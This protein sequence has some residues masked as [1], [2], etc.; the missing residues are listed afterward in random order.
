V[1]KVTLEIGWGVGMCESG[2]NPQPFNN[3]SDCPQML[4][5]YILFGGG[6]PYSDQYGF[7]ELF[8][9]TL[10]AW[11]GFFILFLGRR[12]RR[13]QKPLKTPVFNKTER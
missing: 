7:D 8:Y 5:G 12:L 2:N 4:P 3:E 1:G 9:G 6:L 13:D 11:L 10:L